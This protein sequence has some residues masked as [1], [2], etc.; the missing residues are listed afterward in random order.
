MA[1]S[2]YYNRGVFIGALHARAILNAIEA[3]GADN[4]TGDDVRK[5]FESISGFTLGGFMPPLNLT[6]EDHEGAAGSR[7]GRS[8]GQVGPAHGTGCRATAT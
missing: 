5:G 4:V 8:G 7:C 3:V 1:V 2:V 6:P